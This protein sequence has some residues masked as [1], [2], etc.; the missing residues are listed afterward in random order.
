LEGIE[1]GQ[2]FEWT[3]KVQIMQPKDADPNLLGFDP[4]DITKTWPWD[5]FPVSNT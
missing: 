3:A 2:E 4:F 5:K 1:A